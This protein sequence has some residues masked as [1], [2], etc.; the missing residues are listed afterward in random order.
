MGVYVNWSIVISENMELSCNWT[1]VFRY[2][3]QTVTWQLVAT[4][5]E[6]WNYDGLVRNFVWKVFKRMLTDT[7]W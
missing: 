1:Y 2:G 6:E 5:L 7:L 4:S 3:I